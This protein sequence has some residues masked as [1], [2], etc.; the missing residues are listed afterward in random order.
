M[1]RQEALQTLQFY[2][3]SP[4]LIRHHL[5]VEAAMRA[6]AQ[7]FISMGVQGI[8][9]ELWGLTGLLHDADYEITRKTPERHTLYLEE[10]L[11]NTLS[12]EAMQAI[13]AHNSKFTNVSPQTILD[14]ALFT[15]DEM[16]GVIV[17][18]ALLQKNKNFSS[19]TP[20]IV[21]AYMNEKSFI[22]SAAYRQIL[23]VE[24]Q[25][26]IPLRE[27]SE[28]VLSSMKPIAN[29]LGFAG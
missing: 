24:I 29:E 25:L 6:L 11:G 13:K 16:T 4:N 28:I 7:K 14:W 20:D 2:T 17:S 15:V 22:K 23:N 21:I 9:I 12:K 19:I 8:D 10:K 5:A 3:K 1:T 26:K 18:V 27:F